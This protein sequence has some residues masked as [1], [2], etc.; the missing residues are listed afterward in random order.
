M[1]VEGRLNQL[2]GVFVN[3][4]PLPLEVRQK[5]VEL[6]LAGTRACH[7]S[8]QLKVSHGCVS[9]ILTRFQR[10]GSILPGS[11]SKSGPI[12]KMFQDMIPNVQMKPRRA[13][14]SFTEPQIEILESFFVKNQYPDAPMREEIAA[15]TDLTE[16][17]VQVWFSNR[18]AKTRKNEKKLPAVKSEP[19]NHMPVPS[20]N[21]QPQMTP[22]D[23]QQYYQYMEVQNQMQHSFYFP[24][25]DSSLIGKKLVY[26]FKLT[27]FQ[28]LI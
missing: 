16:N 20:F 11:Q 22:F 26:C 2:G 23:M 24:S 17:R 27:F 18:R 21:F 8:R 25:Y 15:E 13:R 19:T 3:G 9:K 14:T 4:R 12:E 28:V 6:H 7:I 5:I 1:S 10:T